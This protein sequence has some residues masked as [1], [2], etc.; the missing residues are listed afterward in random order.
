M[1]RGWWRPVHMFWVVHI[2]VWHVYMYFTMLLHPSP[3]HPSPLPFTSFTSPLH[4]LHPSPPHP[5]PL[6]STSFTPPLH[7]LLPSPPHPSPLPSPPLHSP[8]RALQADFITFLITEED[9]KEIGVSTLGAQ[10]KLQIAISGVVCSIWIFDFHTICHAHAHT[11]THTHIHTHTQ[12]LR[13]RGHSLSLPPSL[14]QEGSAYSSCLP[15]LP[16]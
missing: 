11:H 10:R 1:C 13:D 4:I 2:P 15:P 7:I 14:R 16:G 8:P 6:P 5:S 12:T 3:P 9:L